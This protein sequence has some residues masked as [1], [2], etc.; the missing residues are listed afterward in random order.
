MANRKSRRR[1]TTQTLRSGVSRNTPSHKIRAASVLQKRAIDRAPP[2]PPLGKISRA[3][4][5]T[6]DRRRHEPT[7]RREP[8][9]TVHGSTAKVV[10][11][12][13]RSRKDRVVRSAEQLKRR[14]YYS[15]LDAW[16]RAGRTGVRP[17]P[18]KKEKP[19]TRREDWRFVSP[20]RVWLCAKRKIR[21]EVLMA[22]NRHG[23]GAKS[24][25]HRNEYSEVHC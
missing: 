21:R 10:Y 2:R 24:Q 13:V 11:D 15:D 4:M 8:P 7:G 22:L 3:A 17:K 16:H 9:K 19:T 5:V 12:N 18:P 23:K 14:K 25:K 1:S 6:E 20:H